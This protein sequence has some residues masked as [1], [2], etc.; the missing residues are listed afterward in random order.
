MAW[1]I[2]D[3]NDFEIE[4]SDGF[5][6]TIIWKQNI[7]FGTIVG[8]ILPIFWHNA[9]QIPSFKSREIDWNDVTSPVVTSAADL[10][11]AIEDMIRSGWAAAGGI[12]DGDYGD[13]TVS[14]TGTAIRSKVRANRV[15]NNINFK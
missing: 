9:A 5:A 11:T 8:D 10:Q 2:T 3:L 7:R 4:L 13:V 15:F 12:T 14:G 1:T 6:T